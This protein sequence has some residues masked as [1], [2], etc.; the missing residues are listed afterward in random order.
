MFHISASSIAI[1]ENTYQSYLSELF[2]PIPPSDSSL[3]N[4]E[5]LLLKAFK[6]NGF[7]LGISENLS[8]AIHNEL[9]YQ[10]K[11]PSEYNA[12]TPLGCALS[13]LEDKDIIFIV[14]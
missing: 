1:I 2:D 5:Q 14:H 7:P 13:M 4:M 8:T 12:S 3:S 11:N 9:Y 10:I 6:E